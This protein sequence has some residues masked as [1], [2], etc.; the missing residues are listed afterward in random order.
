MFS[1]FLFLVTARISGPVDAIWP[2]LFNLHF[3]ID[4][5]DSSPAL[6]VSPPP[7]NTRSREIINDAT[8]EKKRSIAVFFEAEFGGLIDFNLDS[9]PTS[10]SPIGDQVPW[11]REYTPESLAP[12]SRGGA[13]T[14]DTEFD[15]MASNYS[16][17]STPQYTPDSSSQTPHRPSPRC[18]SVSLRSPLVRKHACNFPNCGYTCSMP[19]DLRKDSIKHL[20]VNPDMTFHCTHEGCGGFSEGGR[21]GDATRHGTVDIDRRSCCDTIEVLARLA[22]SQ[23]SLVGLKGLMVPDELVRRG[24]MM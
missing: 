16:P 13:I 12:I 10:L 7:R 5:T 24:A 15:L 23:W 19:K 20:G 9:P 14:F 11:A 1:L 2:G 8:E 22:R 21:M 17:T 4:F 18:F 3:P 6:C